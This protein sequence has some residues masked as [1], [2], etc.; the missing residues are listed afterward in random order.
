MDTND[1]IN[2]LNRQIAEL[3]GNQAPAPEPTPAPAPVAP[4]ARKPISPL[5]M[6]LVPVAAVGV[7][8]GGVL[9]VTNLQNVVGNSM[10]GT[11]LSLPAAPT[12][13]DNQTLIDGYI[14]DKGGQD[15][16]YT[17]PQ[18]PVAPVVQ[19]P[20]TATGDT[21]FTTA[22]A[23][24]NGIESKGFGC[25]VINNE[26]G[27]VIVKWDDGITSTFHNYN[28]PN[29]TIT[30]GGKVNTGT[31]DY[32]YHEGDKYLHFTSDKGSENWIPVANMNF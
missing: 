8:G 3:E 19:P 7:L 32:V 12:S 6:A 29:D 16:P 5:M 23:G 4:K 14:G 9:A 18:A 25:S 22:Y 11:S 20:V 28:G 21:C 26:P 30:V 13:S 27:V 15:T 1:R 2:E 17:K 24:S 31:I 10:G